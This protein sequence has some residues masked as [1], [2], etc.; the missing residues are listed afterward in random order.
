MIIA[1]K[2]SEAG[3]K[4]CYKYTSQ[5]WQGYKDIPEDRIG[6]AMFGRKFRYISG[7]ESKN[8]EKESQV[9]KKIEAGK[10]EEKKPEEE[11]NQS[12]HRE[13]GLC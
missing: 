11:T 3:K 10:E 8:Q 1:T 9:E 2:E 6:R 4:P 12:S 13:A 5:Q 7:S